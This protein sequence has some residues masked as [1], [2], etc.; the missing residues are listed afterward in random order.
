MD[1][2]AELEARMCPGCNTDLLETIDTEPED[3]Q[4][5]PPVQCGKCALIGMQQDAFKGTQI[6]SW[7]WGAVIKKL[8]RRRG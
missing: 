5:L 3:W 2:L 8:A 6:S 4:A 7:R 1:A